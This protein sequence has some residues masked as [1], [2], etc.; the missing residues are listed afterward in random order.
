M[1]KTTYNV[2]NGINIIMS[3]LKFHGKTSIEWKSYFLKTQLQQNK[4]WYLFYMQGYIAPNSGMFLLKQMSEQHKH[5]EKPVY[6]PRKG[7]N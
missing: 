7:H 5:T 2:G 6:L 4:Q 3:V 1:L